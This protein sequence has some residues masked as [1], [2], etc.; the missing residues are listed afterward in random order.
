MRKIL[1]ASAVML[2]PLISTLFGASLAADTA[3]DVAYHG[4]LDTPSGNSWVTGDNGGTGFGAWTLSS[5]TGGFSIGSSAGNGD[6]GGGALPLTDIDTSHV[7][8]ND[9][10]S[11]RIVSN[12]GLA[13][14]TRGFTGGALS[15]GQTF[16][17]GFDNG[18]VD[19]NPSFADGDAV[20]KVGFAL[21]SS[22]VTRFEFS[23]T[24]G[25]GS[26]RY[27]VN[28]AT[29]GGNTAVGSFADE[30][31]TTA[32]TLTGADS[33]L[34]SV[35][36]LATGATE[37]FSGNLLNSGG[38]DNVHLSV[39]NTTPAVGLPTP[40]ADVYYNSMSI[41]PEPS[42]LAMLLTAGVILLRRRRG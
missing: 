19:T 5:A 15:I 13:E 9:T 10:R 7:A 18:F 28:A 21:R 2:S 4:L 29:G 42:S 6:G 36:Y 8:V 11:W 32:F 41:V 39:F 38:L 34:F 33:Y 12:D 20:G 24:G 22:G 3:S 30:G 23:N 40:T 17:L 31:V 14:A 37:N 25:A 27:V 1:I 26:N 35:T 16:N